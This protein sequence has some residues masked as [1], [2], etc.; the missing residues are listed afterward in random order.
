[1]NKIP[2][3]N[4]RNNNEKER[5]EGRKRKLQEHGQVDKN[6]REINGGDKKNVVKVTDL[7]VAVDLGEADL[8]GVLEGAVGL[9]PP[10]PHR[11]RRDGPAAGV[12]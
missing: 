7:E 9:A 3:N 12:R 6:R 1:M 5:K 2:Y 8:G 4:S 11:D 10:R